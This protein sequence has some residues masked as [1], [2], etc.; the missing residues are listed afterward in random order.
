M[1]HG[2][3]RPPMFKRILFIAKKGQTYGHYG[4]HRKSS[5]LSNSAKFVVDMLREQGYH[6]KLVQ[7]VDNNDIDREVTEF[8]PDVAIIEALWVV[9]K[10][11]S[12]LSRLHPH[13]KWVVRVHSELSFL[14]QEGIAIDWI[15]EYIKHKNVYVGFN[16]A[17][18]F[19]DFKGI[20]DC[21]K[22][23]YLPNFFPLRKREH[24]RKHKQHLDVGCFGAIRPLKN[25]LIQAV[26][27]IEYANSKRK[28]L[29]FHINATRVECGQ[30]V[31]KNIRALFAHTQNELVE[32]RWHNHNDFQRVMASMDVAMCVSLTESFCIVAA[33]AASLGVPLV[34]SPE[35]RW[36]S[37]YSQTEPTNVDSIVRTMDTVLKYDF[38]FFNRRGLRKY[39][40]ES[41]YSW[42]KFLR[43][44]STHIT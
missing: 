9:P 17:H 42:E 21:H 32:H 11:F 37:C 4:F 18:A 22:L 8:R 7:V 3:E 2:I 13:V 38:S 10:K 27:A 40:Q 20:A 43:Q 29:R 1:H 15:F 34:C 6:A 36:A 5:G 16:S 39:D 26:A 24:I 19:S 28:K 23:V 30:E 12:V 14:A 25:Q 35:V 31:L 44:I 41:I 33:D